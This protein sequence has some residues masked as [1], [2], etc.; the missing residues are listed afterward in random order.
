MVKVLAAYS[1]PFR[2]NLTGCS[3]CT[4]VPVAHKCTSAPVY[5]R[6]ILLPGLAT[7]LHSL[8]RVHWYTISERSS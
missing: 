7:H 6:H 2:L 4:S 5:I 3:K 1:Q 8:P